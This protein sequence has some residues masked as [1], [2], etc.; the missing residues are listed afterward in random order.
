MSSR[1]GCSLLKTS[2]ISPATH[3]LTDLFSAGQFLLFYPTTKGAVQKNVNLLQNPKIL[4]YANFSNSTVPT[5]LI[6]I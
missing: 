3:L 1:S 4:L 2:T 6:R 5:P